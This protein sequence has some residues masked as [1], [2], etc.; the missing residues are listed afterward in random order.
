VAVVVA[1]VAAAAISA[2]ECHT[3]AFPVAGWARAA[4]SIAAEWALGAP[5][6]AVLI[7]TVLEQ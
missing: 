1:A 3:A 5:V 6:G 7:L 2:V 4:V